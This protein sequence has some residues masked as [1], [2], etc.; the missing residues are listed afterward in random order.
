MFARVFPAKAYDITLA[1]IIGEDIYIVSNRHMASSGI[2][3]LKT[4]PEGKAVLTSF[5][6]NLRGAGTLTARRSDTGPVMEKRE[7][8][9]HVFEGGSLFSWR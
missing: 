5:S 1:R 7:M 9:P 4:T 6:R 3:S 8:K 2:S